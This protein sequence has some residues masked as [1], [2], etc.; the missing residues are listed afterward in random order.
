MC[1]RY[2][3]VV[4]SMPKAHQDA[5]GLFSSYVFKANGLK[6][7]GCL[8]TW[9]V[10][11]KQPQKQESRNWGIDLGGCGM[12]QQLH[13]CLAK[14]YLNEKDNFYLSQLRSPVAI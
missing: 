13:K 10:E 4:K 7:F 12:E 1:L 11:F 5:S 2:V 8:N 9:I 6:H 3:P 14:R